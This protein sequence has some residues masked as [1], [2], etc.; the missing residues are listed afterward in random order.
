MKNNSML[1]LLPLLI[2]AASSAILL[3]LFWERAHDA[4]FLV[5]AGLFSLALANIFFGGLFAD[6]S[7]KGG[8][9]L[10]NIGV[11]YFFASITFIAACTAIGQALVGVDRA[12]IVASIVTVFLLVVSL[13]IKGFVKS[14]VDSNS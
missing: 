8:G 13:I 5:A 4:V 12:A 3:V 14:A 6:L 10:A 11:H 2:F 1:N 9:N 7:Q